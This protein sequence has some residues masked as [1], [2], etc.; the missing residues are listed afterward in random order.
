MTDP[1]LLDFPDH[2]ET[3]RLLLRAPRPGDGAAGNA[4]ICASIAELKTWMPWAQITPTVAETEAVYRR[5]AA[6]TSRW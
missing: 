5:G 6:K 3:E 4:A 1:V 2:F